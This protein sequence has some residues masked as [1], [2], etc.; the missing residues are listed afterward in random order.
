MDIAR[1]IA[2]ERKFE[3]EFVLF[4]LELIESSNGA[5]NSEKQTEYV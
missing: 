5:N 2:R 3:T 1:L 4:T